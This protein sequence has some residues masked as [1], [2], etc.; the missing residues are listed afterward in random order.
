MTAATAR[1]SFAPSLA[2][3]LALAM[4]KCPLCAIALLSAFGIELHAVAPVTVALILGPVIAIAL[5]RSSKWPPLLALA[6]ALCALA[7]RFVADVPLLFHVGVGAIVVGAAAN[8]VLA[9]RRKCA[10]CPQSCEPTN[11]NLTNH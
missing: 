3:L 1:S 10:G 8:Y 4:P 9:L 2:A 11:T 6:G 7:G 5:R